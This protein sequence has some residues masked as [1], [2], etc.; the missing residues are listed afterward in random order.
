MGTVV[1]D[2]LSSE[3]G[4]DSDEPGNACFDHEVESDNEDQEH[5]EW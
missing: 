5:S 1:G 3:D 2:P 4:S